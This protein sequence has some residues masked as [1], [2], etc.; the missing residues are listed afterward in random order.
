M[1]VKTIIH[2]EIPA[3]DA[4]KLSKFYSEVFGWKFEKSP[5]Q[6]MEYWLIATGPRGRS[7]GG[8]MY[9]KAGPDDKPKNY[10]RVNKIDQQIAA[11]K[12]AGGKEFVGKMQVPGM[13][14]SFI[15]LDPE[16]NLIGLFEPT[17]P[18]RTRPRRG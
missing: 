6:D 2:F 1:V 8:G 16:G 15:G 5:M 18:S 11:F 13:G 17:R 12:K 7:I 9:K 10:I 14:W 3:E 4:A